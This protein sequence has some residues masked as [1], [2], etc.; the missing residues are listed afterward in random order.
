MAWKLCLFYK[1]Y[2][3]KSPSCLYNLIPDRMKFYSTRS[4]Q[5]NNISNIKTR[6]NF[7]RNSF[8][9]S[10]ITEWNK[11]DRDVLNSD[12]LN[13]CK[14]SLLKLVRPVANSIFEINNSYGLKLLTRLCLGLSNLRY[15]KFRHNF[16]TLLTQYVPVV[17]KQKLQPISSFTA[18]SFNLLDN[19][20]WLILRKLMKTFWKN[21]ANLLQKYF[22]M[23]MKNLTFL[24][25]NV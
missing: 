6:S 1:I 10:T 4:S 7:V 25:A 9:A 14:L 23:A 20:S 22:C 15:H 8:F 16:I 2:K 13:V 19:L 17:Y 18:P 24:V 21:M 11:L 3:N 12:S 5:I